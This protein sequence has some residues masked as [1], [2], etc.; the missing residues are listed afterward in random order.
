MKDSVQWTPN[1]Y[2]K[3][4]SPADIEPGRP[5]LIRLGYTR[6]PVFRLESVSVYV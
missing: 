3:M 5:A 1:Y 2:V 6:G 4:L